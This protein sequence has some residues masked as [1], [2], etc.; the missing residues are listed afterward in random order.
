LL[1]I[2]SC[3]RRQLPHVPSSSARPRSDQIANRDESRRLAEDCEVAA[4]GH[5]CATPIS[6]GMEIYYEHTRREQMREGV[7]ESAA[8]Q[9]SLDCPISTKR[10]NASCRNIP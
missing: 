7:L 6:P 5:W 9:S 1:F 3:R 10:A 8:H 2:R 4:S